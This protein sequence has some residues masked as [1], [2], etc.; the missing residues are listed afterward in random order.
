MKKIVKNTLFIFTFFLL[1]NCHY[2]SQY[3]DRVSDKNEAEKI[4]N[5][6]YD[7][8]KN[9]KYKDSYKL[10]SKTFWKGTDSIQFSNLLNKV[11]EKFGKI[12]DIKL[13][14]W[15]TKVIIGSN[16]KSEYVLYYLNKY[17][18]Y[19]AKETITLVKEDGVIK[20]VGYD[21]RS[22]GFVNDCK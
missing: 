14:H 8:I 15:N 2:N 21:I 3:I 10:I 19:E 16:S 13:H 1:S 11:Q 12:Q 17:E 4:T 18:K 20:I 5:I 9:N 7:N 6:F 22:D